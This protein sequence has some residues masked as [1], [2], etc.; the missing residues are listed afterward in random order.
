[1]LEYYVYAYIRRSDGT[2]YYIGKGKGNR[3]YAK[4]HSVSVPLDRTK[5]VF[6][7]TN[8]TD[9]GACAIERRMIRW[10]GRK[11][12]GTGILHNRTDGG[13]GASGVIMTPLKRELYRITQLGIK[14]P[15]N[16]RPGSRNFFYGKKHT[17]ERITYFSDV[18]LGDKN[19]MFG[20]KQNRVSCIRCHAET[21]VNSLRHH[22][23]CFER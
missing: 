13:D 21:S 10:Y 19:P 6:L 18:K 5:I 3:A 2:P 17:D 15:A 4:E 9:I 16:S 7:E 20:K 14:K 8:L 12:I 23:K 1:M 22:N 11:D